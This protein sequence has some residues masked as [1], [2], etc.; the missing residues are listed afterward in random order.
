MISEAPKNLNSKKY[1]LN[2]KLFLSSQHNI[3]EER[4]IIPPLKHSAQQNLFKTNV[5]KS[6]SNLC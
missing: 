5:E 2:N 4:Q 3:P 1:D 6:R